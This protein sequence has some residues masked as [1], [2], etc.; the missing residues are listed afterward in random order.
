MLKRVRVLIVLVFL[1]FIASALPPS[2][3][4]SLR[5][6]SYSW[7]Q[8]P[9]SWSEEIATFFR[10]LIFF[11]QNANEN[12]RLKDKL[13]QI[14]MRR[15]DEQEL[16]LENKRLS[17][18]LGLSQTIPPHVSRVVYARVIG[19]S[20][21]FWNKS[22]LM[23]KGGKDGIKTGRLVLSEFCLV[24]KTV[25]VGPT[26]SRVLLITDPGIKI[27]VTV[28]RTRQQGVLYGTPNG[29]ARVKYLSLDQE[30]K[31]GDVVQTAGL[32]NLFPKAIPV[33]IVEKSWKEPGQIYQVAKIK[34]IADFHRLEE[35]IYVE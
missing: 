9:L 2:V 15:L 24:G 31:P 4:S 26:A 29:E 18:L 33:G 22:L 30:I 8:Y 7:L 12:R 20:P 5:S 34:P 28:Q 19:R 35:L 11:R 25:E 16:F 6:H 17:K 27:A 21:S 10:D 32:R 14:A 3:S 23:D 1:V 13:S